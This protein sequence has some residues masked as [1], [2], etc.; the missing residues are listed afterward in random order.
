MAPL[1]GQWISGLSNGP[2]T[3]RLPVLFPIRAYVW[4][5]GSIPN[6]GHAGGSPWMS[7]SLSRSLPLYLKFNKNILKK[8]NGC[9]VQSPNPLILQRENH[10]P[11]R[12]N[13]S[14]VQFWSRVCTSVV[15]R[16]RPWSGHAGGNQSVW[17]YYID[18]S[19]CP[20]SLPP[21]HSI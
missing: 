20:L 18:V 13:E 3:I 14:R 8:K 16:P 12:T 2:C 1:P 7:L 15:V 5:A 11:L 19:L 10:G 4:A 6:L 17:L 21:S 9:L